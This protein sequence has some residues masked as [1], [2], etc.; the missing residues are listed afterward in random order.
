ML[1][2]VVS[3]FLFVT[4]LSPFV[5]TTPFLCVCVCV[6]FLAHANERMRVKF[7]SFLSVNTGKCERIILL[8]TADANAKTN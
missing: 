3:S 5:R 6:C 8:P 1:L 2:Y 4:L 7:P